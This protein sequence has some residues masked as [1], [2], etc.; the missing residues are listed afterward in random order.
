M[1]VDV[2]GSDP[3]KVGEGEGYSE[4]TPGE[5]RLIGINGFVDGRNVGDECIPLG[6]NV[7]IGADKVAWVGLNV[8][9]G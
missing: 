8:G 2:G 5:I 7:A 6:D 4:S 3:S 9:L 1:L